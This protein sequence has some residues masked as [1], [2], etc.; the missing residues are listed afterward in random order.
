MPK[1]SLDM[2]CWIDREDNGTQTITIRVTGL[3]N[4]ALAEAV[5]LWLRDMVKDSS[6]KMSGPI[7][8]RHDA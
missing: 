4:Y 6:D 8:F 1:T 7:T 2:N 5:A 3:P